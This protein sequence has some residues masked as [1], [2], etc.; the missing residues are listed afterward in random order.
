MEV[1]NKLDLW[2]PSICNLEIELEAGREYHV[3]GRDDGIKIVFDRNCLI[4]PWPEMTGNECKAKLT[5]EC[6]KR[7]CFKFKGK[8]HRKL[9]KKTRKG[10]CS[11]VIRELC[12]NKL[13]FDE[14]ILKLKDGA[15]CEMQ[16]LCD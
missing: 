4:E 6:I 15:I 7:P 14:Y 11:K 8:K 16:N 9:C 3:Q 5:R 2:L 10:M 13:E 1:G 12:K